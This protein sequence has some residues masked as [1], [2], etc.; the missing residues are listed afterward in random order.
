MRLVLLVLLAFS[1]TAL[2]VKC[3]SYGKEVAATLRSFFVGDDEAQK[4]EVSGEEQ[5]AKYPQKPQIPAPPADT[6]D[7]GQPF[8]KESIPINLANEQSH[9]QQVHWKSDVL[10]LDQFALQ[11]VFQ[12]LSQKALVVEK[13]MEMEAQLAR[14]K[15]TCQAELAKIILEHEAAGKKLQEELDRYMTEAEIFLNLQSKQK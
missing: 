13:N 9:P 12:L 14:K 1:N 11:D 5:F 7:F 10:N 6:K 15:S 3:G 2:A 4:C 8:H